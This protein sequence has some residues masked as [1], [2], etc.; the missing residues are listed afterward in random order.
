MSVPTSSPVPS[1]QTDCWTGCHAVPAFTARAGCGTPVCNPATRRIGR[2]T[3]LA[4]KPSGC[5]EYIVV[6]ELVHLLEP[7]HNARFVA[8]M[9]TFLPGWA[10]RRDE[11]NRLP[12]R[13]ADWGY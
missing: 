3:D 6:H 10:Y 5:L 4:K 9:D 12:L 11:L 8:L 1:A 13:H 7:I 2:N